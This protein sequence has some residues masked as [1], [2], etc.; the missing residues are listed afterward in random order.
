MMRNQFLKKQN[1]KII[2]EVS[3]RKKI[4]KVEIHGLKSNSKLSKR[5]QA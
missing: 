5:I 3:K 1:K 4:L 2:N